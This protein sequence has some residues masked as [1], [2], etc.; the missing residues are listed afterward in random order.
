MKANEYEVPTDPKTLSQLVER[1][2]PGLPKTN[3]VCGCMN[4]PAEY[5]ANDMLGAD[6]I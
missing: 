2:Q 5:D 3:N 6:S 4:P 1:L